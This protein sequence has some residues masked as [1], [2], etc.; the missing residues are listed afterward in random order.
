[1]IRTY[2][3]LITLPTFKERYDYL[4][5]GDRV[6]SETFGFD[7]YLNQMFYKTNEWKRIRHYV[8]SRD[9]ACDLA[10]SDR[11]IP[12]GVRI[13]IHHMNPISVDDILMKREWILDPEF[14]ICTTKQTHDAIHYGSSELI[15]DEC[16]DRK[17]NDTCL[18]R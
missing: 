7:R 8:I 1:M 5:I 13:L 10:F 12:N 11:E 16:I 15:I 14:L 9:N 3:K 18:W 17:P 2:S 6:G 4:K